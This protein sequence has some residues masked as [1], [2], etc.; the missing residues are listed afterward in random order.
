MNYPLTIELVPKTSWY[1]NVRSKVS[2]EEWDIIRKKAYNHSNYV[3]EICSDH[4]L[5]Q[6]FQHPVECH[7]IW[8]FDNIKQI[9]TL[10]GFIS[11]CPLCH[12]VKHIGLTKI[13]GEEKLAINQ[14]IKVNNI[15]ER[16][17]K[18]YIYES[19]KIWKQRNK[20]NWKV[21]ISY[22]KEYLKK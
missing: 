1:N 16:T 14:L 13:K 20:Y 22:I 4:G 12:K 17:A 10:I 11:L 21:D 18:S 2:K 8:K 19:L 15:G 7:E 9:Q 5:N 3:C 6:G